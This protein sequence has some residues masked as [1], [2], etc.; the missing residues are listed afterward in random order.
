[1]MNCGSFFAPIR[2][3]L[4][5]YAYAGGGSQPPISAAGIR[6]HDCSPSRQDRLFKSL[7]LRRRA[8]PAA[9]LAAAADFVNGTVR[10][11]SRWAEIMEGM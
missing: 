1:M 7:S 3:E 5:R 6:R 8:S 9:S 4:P 11:L 10:G 2:R